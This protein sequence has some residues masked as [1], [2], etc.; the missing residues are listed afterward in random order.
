MNQDLIIPGRKKD[1]GGFAV[2]RTIPAA[3]KRQ[4]GPFVFLDHMGP[5]NVD[6]KH[7]LDVRPHPHIGLATVTYLFSG[8]GHHRDTLG[9][10]QV[11][12][13][14]DINLMTAGRG[15]AH[16][17]R[18]PQE[19][20][21]DDSGVVF[22]GVQLWVALPVADEEC[23]PS[24]AHFSEQQLPS[25]FL[26]ESSKGKL[27][28]GCHGGINSP[29]MMRSETLF[30]DIQ[31]SATGEGKVHFEAEEVGLFLVKGECTINGQIL[32]P[33]DLIVL[34]DSKNVT[35]KHSAD[36]RIVVIG[37]EKYPE[38][39]YIWWNFVSSRKER[40]REAA[41]AWERQEFGKVPSEVDFIP[42]PKDPLP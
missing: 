25:I 36:A 42:L 5:M 33:E 4:V 2:H 30:M 26:T 38:P 12:L 37:G 34:S 40:I 9:S 21:V 35:I 39:R 28:I 15:I 10:S 31:A 7:L 11:I 14:G 32:K 1:L 22:H 19:D 17:E 3:G 13:P 20:R 41:R 18:T 8:R 16:S 23:D 6:T 29:V 24:F 27:L